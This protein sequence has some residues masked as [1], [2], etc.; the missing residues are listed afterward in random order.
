MANCPCKPVVVE[1][2]PSFAWTEDSNCH[3]LQI[4][5]PGIDKKILTI[6]IL[7]MVLQYLGY[8]SVNDICLFPWYGFLFLQRSLLYEDKH[9]GYYI[10]S[11]EKWRNQDRNS[12]FSSNISTLN[13]LKSYMMRMLHWHIFLEKIPSELK[14]IS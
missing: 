13:S 11:V 9:N 2:E 8:F 7:Y 1:T 3:Y 4:D 14:L 10:I 12:W 6:T 5:I